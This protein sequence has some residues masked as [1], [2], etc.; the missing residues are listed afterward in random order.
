MPPHPL[1]PPQGRSHRDPGAGA[2]SMYRNFLD[3]WGGT[4]GSQ[5]GAYESREAWTEMADWGNGK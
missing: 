2:E 3:R 1:H 5:S 4:P